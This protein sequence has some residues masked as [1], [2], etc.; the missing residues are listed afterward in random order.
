MLSF[1]LWQVTYLAMAA[2]AAFAFTLL[3]EAP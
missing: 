2:V 3:R 1:G